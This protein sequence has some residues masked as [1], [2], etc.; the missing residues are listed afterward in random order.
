[1]QRHAVKAF[2]LRRKISCSKTI[3]KF[4][5]TTG[6]TSLVFYNLKYA[7]F[8]DDLFYKID[9]SSYKPISIYLSIDGSGSMQEENKWKSVLANTIALGYMSYPY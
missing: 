2:I 6:T 4:S 1:M 5:N 9:K 7:N 8:E 3:K